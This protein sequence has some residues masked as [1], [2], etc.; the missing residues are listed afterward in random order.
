LTEDGVAKIGG[1]IARSCFVHHRDFIYE[2]GKNLTIHDRLEGKGDARA[3][4]YLQLAP[5]LRSE[6]GNH[7][8]LVFDGNFLVCR[9]SVSNPKHQASFVCGESEPAIGGW[10]S[11]QYLKKVPATTII[12]LF[13]NDVNE[14]STHI[15][16]MP[17]SPTIRSDSGLP[18]FRGTL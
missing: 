12:F 6:I 1:T 7:C 5:K 13:D 10:R 18:N 3:I 15:D 4:L 2:A 11:Y 8:T 16:I 14:F 9:I 17:P